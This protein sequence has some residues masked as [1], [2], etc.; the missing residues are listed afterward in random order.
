MNKEDLIMRHKEILDLHKVTN[1][2]LA[3]SAIFC[4]VRL[5][6]LEKALINCNKALL[7]QNNYIPFLPC[8]GEGWSVSIDPD[9]S[10][11][12][13]G[14][15]FVEVEFMYGEHHPD[16]D[17]C[18]IPILLYKN[19]IDERYSNFKS[20]NYFSNGQ[21]K[22]SGNY[23]NGERQGLWI[24]YY[25]NENIKCKGEYDQFKKVKIWEYFYD[26]GQIKERKNYDEPIYMISN[27][28]WFENGQIRG[29]WKI[30]E[31]EHSIEIKWYFE[32]GELRNQSKKTLDDKYMDGEHITYFKNGNYDT[33]IVTVKDRIIQYR[34]YNPDGTVKRI[35]E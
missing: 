31:E 24:E 29:D 21:I 12:V 23:L 14:R 16:S 1:T 25:Q 8:P 18:H 35:S 22:R 5:E 28:Q 10:V 20:E 27:T 6:E 7:A 15:G 2:R 32:T 13:R 30:N 34:Y 26:N 4:E 3:I 17:Y 19:L 11:E 33:V 9:D